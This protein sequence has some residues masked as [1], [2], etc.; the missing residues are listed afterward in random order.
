M[1]QNYYYNQLILQYHRT[2]RKLI[3]LVNSGKNLRRILMLKKRLIKLLQMLGG[4]NKAFKTG[5]AGSAFAASVLLFQPNIAEA[6]TPFTGNE[7][8]PFHQTTGNRYYV[9]DDATGNNDG[10]SWQDAFTDLQSALNVAVYGDEIWVAEGTYIP[11]VDPNG[12]P[13][14]VWLRYRTFFLRSGIKLYGGFAGTETS[15]EERNIA[16]HPAVLSGGNAPMYD[17]DVNTGNDFHVMVA[18]DDDSNTEVNGFTFTH[19]NTNNPLSY[20]ESLFVGSIDLQYYN[21]GSDI[22]NINADPIITNCTFTVNTGSCLSSVDAAPAISNCVFSNNMYGAIGASGS[23]LDKTITVNNCKFFNHYGTVVTY[24]GVSMVLD[25]CVFSNN[26]AEGGLG[27]VVDGFG[28]GSSTIKNCIFSGNLGTAIR[29]NDASFDIT[30]SLITQNSGNGY[31]IW[32]DYSSDPDQHFNISNS[33]VW[34]NSLISD[35]ENHSPS[36][37]VFSN[38]IIEGSGGSSN[39]SLN[40]TDGGGN[41]DTDPLFVNASDADGAD[42]IL[43]T[44]DDGIIPGCGPAINAGSN[45][46]AEDTTDITGAVRIQNNTVDMGPYETDLFAPSTA[47]YVDADGDGFGNPNIITQ[48][49]TQPAGY[50]LNNT[51]CND[52]NA[53][54]HPK[55]FYH[56]ADGDGYGNPNDSVIACTKPAGYVVNKRDCDDNNVTVH[57]GAPEICGDG[58]DNNCNGLVDETCVLVSIA[59]ASVV[60][61]PKAQRVMNF[62]VTLNKKS[63]QTVT[64]DYKTQDGSASAGSDY[65]AQSGTVTFNAGTKKAIISITIDG[66][67]IPEA[68]E[69]FTILLSNPVNASLNDGEATGTIVNY[70]TAG[71]ASLIEEKNG[72]GNSNAFTIA[73]NP[74]SSRINIS[75]TNY[76]GNVTVQLVSIQGKIINQE[77]IQTGNAKYTQQQ[78]NISDIAS[79]T[80]FLVVID[81]K[82]NRK[83]N[84]VIITR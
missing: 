58:I 76:T 79:G 64:V 4:Y 81:E 83:T 77:K 59:D 71:F 52:K 42:D 54:I 60:E 55:A 8:T 84:K 39:W 24:Y 12:D 68:N 21:V 28:G 16:A 73:P 43:G 11:T 7:K 41:L 17:D 32:I 44:A 2:Q 33:V 35:F 38:N 36:P 3:N 57:P 50:V 1:K 66:D 65:E 40:A 51:D 15:I 5:L 56:D 20:S 13:N 27:A 10:S 78:M 18:I 22:L 63:S 53:N 80:Y 75:L 46:F 23:N 45:S 19:G 82:G 37:V 61:K 72:Y 62:P 31:G 47:W 34:G 30:N 6:R 74:A 14:P 69:T 29:D 67:K 49:C 48:S 25:K 26:S 70:N 9:N